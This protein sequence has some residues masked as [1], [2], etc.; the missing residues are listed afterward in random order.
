MELHPILPPV[1]ATIKRDKDRAWCNVEFGVSL[2]HLTHKPNQRTNTERERGAKR[3]PV[4]ASLSLQSWNVMGR[5]SH[6]CRTII[7]PHQGRCSIPPGQQGSAAPWHSQGRKARGQGRLPSPEDQRHHP[8]GA[9]RQKEPGAPKPPA[10]PGL[11]CRQGQDPEALGGQAEEMELGSNLRNLGR[12]KQGAGALWRAV[13]GMG[14]QGGGAGRKGGGGWGE[15]S[16]PTA[17]CSH[18]DPT[19]AMW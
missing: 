8:A 9:Q 12:H 2:Q 7:M 3:Q 18:L 4:G 19:R 15:P 6:T 11:G 16:C 14:E 5:K 1:T 17:S 13:L 10:V